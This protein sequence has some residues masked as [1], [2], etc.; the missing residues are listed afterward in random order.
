MT[1]VTTMLIEKRLDA[2]DMLL[3][4]EVEIGPFESAPELAGRLARVGAD[5]LVETLAALEQ[6]HSCR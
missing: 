6:E 4:R 1:G 3:K 2:G 5:L